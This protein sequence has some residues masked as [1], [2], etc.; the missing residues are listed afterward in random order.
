MSNLPLEGIRVIEIGLGGVAPG[1]TKQLG[2]FGAQV[3]KVESKTKPDIMRG[4]AAHKREKAVAF[5]VHHRN[6]LGLGV[7]LKTPMGVEIVRRLIKVSDVI[8]ENYS[9]GVMERWGLDYEHV[10]QIKPDIIMFSGR[11]LGSIGPKAWYKLWGP[12]FVPL[13]GLTD[14]WSFPGDPKP[15]GSATNY[16]DYFGSRQGAFAVLAAL[17]YRA[18]TGKGQYIDQ[19]HAE[20]GATLMGH[21]YLDWAANRRVW[22][23]RGN[24]SPY[25][26]PHSCYRC[27][28]EDRW[29]V[30]DVSTDEEWRSLCNAMGNPE[31]T[32]D[33][34]FATLAR[35]LENVN[36]LDRLIEQ[37]TINLSP[38]EVMEVLQEAGVPAGVVQNGQDLYNDPH[39]RGRGFLVDINHPV[40]GDVTYEGIPMK[41][42]ET[43]GSVRSA[44]PMIG[45]HTRLVCTEILGMSSG[46]VEDLIVEG[47]LD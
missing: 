26:A 28:G 35:R 25:A 15:W 16:A 11:G 47:V 4:T 1:L 33:V 14:F 45:Q 31:W 17:L 8:A 37:W 39:L 7:N 38:Y 40:M 6:K 42:S 9:L 27:S 21:V 44:A 19:A 43:P 10:R 3:I 24:H 46:E 5:A 18:K 32:K 22:K 41:L 20:A 36:E 12:N 23:P 34:R 2:D 29:C 30:I 13:I